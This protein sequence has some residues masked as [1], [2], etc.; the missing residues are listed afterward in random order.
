MNN[1]LTNY[2]YL[3]IIISFVALTTLISIVALTGWWISQHAFAWN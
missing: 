1:K 3:Y 2:N